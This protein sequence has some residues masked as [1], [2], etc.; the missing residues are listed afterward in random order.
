MDYDIVNIKDHPDLVE[1]IIRLG[2]SQRQT[3][4]FLPAQAFR[5]YAKNGSIFVAVSREKHVVGYVLF[6]R[7]VNRVCRL[8]HVCVDPR[9]RKQGVGDSL[10]M[11]LKANTLQMDRV[12]V[13]CRRDYGI[14]HFWEK[15]GFIA[16]GEKAG[17]GFGENTLTLWEYMLRPSLLSLPPERTKPLAVLDLNV[18]IE[19]GAKEG[20]ECRA[21][22]SF[23]YSDEIEFRISEHSFSE[24]NRNCNKETR[25]ATRGWLNSLLR[26]ESCRDKGLVQSVLDIVGVANKD[27]AEQIASAVCSNAE[28]FITKDAR[29][30]SCF[31][32]IQ[33]EF[34]LNIYTPTEF[35][36]NYCNGSGR[37]L[38]F[39]G[40]LNNSEILFRPICGLNISELFHRYKGADEK[41]SSF[42]SCLTVDNPDVRAHSIFQVVVGGVNVGVCVQE[43]VGSCLVVRMLRL[44]K[45]IKHLHT[46]CVHVVENILYNSL[47]LGVDEVVVTDVGIDR[48]VE[49]SLVEAGFYQC[50][51]GFVRSVG[52][53]FITVDDALDRIGLHGG[54][55]VGIG[56]KELV[57]IERSLWP[58]KLIDLDI[59]I[60]VIP[61][62]P[63]WA[64]NLVSARGH[65]LSLVGGPNV[66]LQTRRVYYRSCRGIPLRSPARIVWYV[67]AERNHCLNK[68]V[69]GVSLVDCVEIGPVKE[70][71][72]KYE[73]FGVYRWSDVFR[74]AKYDQDA[75]IMAIVFEKTEIFG[76]ILELSL[77]ASVIKNIEGRTLNTVSPFKI[78]RESFFEIYKRGTRRDN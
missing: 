36:V 39:P 51:R 2:D 26:I 43:R 55:N 11:H 5:D 44:L 19:A 37:D 50:E 6:A 65:Q 24:V 61:I 7:K 38:Y 77:L 47:S 14:D 48:L 27:D 17:R 42:G 28:Y 46:I 32:I 58:A 31:E 54:A 29:L 73:R 59:P 21:L 70:L 35:V 40:Y 20:G 52:H 41:K 30:K 72:K 75:N 25:D 78:C 18:V 74:S 4:G 57:E 53:G 66:M 16:R 49:K 8:T 12:I 3:L 60:Y 62:K 63:Q 23:T 10:V 56:E 13:K 15:N 64:K 67:T 71:Y 68:C 9:W 1:D 33:R 45:S 22:S 76:K 69:V 34:G